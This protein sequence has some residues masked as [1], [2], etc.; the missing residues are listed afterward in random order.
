M[1][2][3]FR[4]QSPVSNSR[5]S[6]VERYNY[7]AYTV[8]D[9]HLATHP[10][11][12]WYTFK[13]EWQGGEFLK[14]LHGAAPISC[15]VPGILG[16]HEDSIKM[17]DFSRMNWLVAGQT[18]SGK[19][20]F[21]RQLVVSMMHFGAPEYLNIV[22]ADPKKNNFEGLRDVVTVVSG[23]E[24]TKQMI[25]ALGKELRE[26]MENLGATSTVHEHNRIMYRSRTYQGVMPYIIFVFDEYAYLLQE[27]KGEERQEVEKEISALASLG[28]GLGI[29]CVFATQAP[30]VKYIE[31]AIKN[32]FERRIAFKLG[33]PQQRGL[34]LGRQPKNIDSEQLFLR[35]GEFILR[36]GG[37]WFR[38]AS[39]LCDDRSLAYA[40]TNLKEHKGGFFL[41][42]M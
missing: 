35:Q 1:F 9:A 21:L 42:K 18:R 28:L 32:N 5:R 23:L 37:K 17:E 31:G 40:A 7:Y 26:R 10:V 38:M 8:F 29:A 4:T 25:I 36:D 12:P 16:T 20:N 22:I 30:Y 6:E 3:F 13:G 34:I 33:D 24:E 27:L 14:A 15:K 39:F 41:K 19:T 2:S 11:H